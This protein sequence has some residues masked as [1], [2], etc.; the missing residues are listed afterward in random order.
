M[1]K[2]NVKNVSKKVFS[3]F[4][5]LSFIMMQRDY[6]NEYLRRQN[7]KLR[8]QLAVASTL[9]DELSSE[10]MTVR[11]RGDSKMGYYG[12]LEE[13]IKKLEEEVKELKEKKNEKKAENKEGGYLEG[14]VHFCVPYNGEPDCGINQNDYME[15]LIDDDMYEFEQIPDD[16]QEEEDESEDDCIMVKPKRTKRA[17]K[18]EQKKPILRKKKVVVAPKEEPE[19][20]EFK[21]DE[22]ESSQASINPF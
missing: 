15:P 8:E 18:K 14:D 6:G 1:V 11:E 21:M 22:S 17:G 10:I 12:L 4:F 3:Y 13:R 7:D 9:I 19:V 5:N 2:R 16:E 20:H